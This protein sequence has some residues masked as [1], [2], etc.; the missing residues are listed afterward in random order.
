[1]KHSVALH[2]D[3]RILQQVLGMDRPEIAPARPEHDGDDVH[4]HLVDQTRD[5]FKAPL[6][7]NG[8]SP[9][10]NQSNSGP[11]WSFSS[12]MK[13]STDTEAYMTTLPNEPPLL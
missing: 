6:S 7:S 2:H 13:P 12:A 4:A 3:V 10:S 8:T 5:T 11:G 1:V 9:L